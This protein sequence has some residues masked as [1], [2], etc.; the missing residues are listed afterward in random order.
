MKKFHKVNPEKAYDNKNK[1]SFVLETLNAHLDE[2]LY[3]YFKESKSI[4]D[5]DAKIEKL[6]EE[7]YTFGNNVMD[8][9]GVIDEDE[10]E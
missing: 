10:N 5:L 4:E 6:L 7:Y 1:C 9:Y 3:Y 8:F 2:K